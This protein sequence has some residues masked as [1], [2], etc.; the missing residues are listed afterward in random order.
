MPHLDS[1]R[2][3]ELALGNGASRDDAD[4]LRHVA[5]CG[6]C[7]EELR[8]LTRVVVAA[9]AVEE[10]DLSAT[11]PER[12]WQCL[13]GALAAAD[14]AASP[15][16]PPPRRV[17]AASARRQGVGSAP[18]ARRREARAALVLLACVLVVWWYRQGR[19]GGPSA[20]TAHVPAHHRRAGGRVR[21]GGVSVR[22]P[23]RR[24]RSG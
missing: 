5:G 2:L 3:A 14:E 9:R 4:A 22:P 10:R 13:V 8:R 19:R 17:R 12:V 15:A 20:G 24:H 16:A 6:P 18:T 1:T 11:P 21:T 23:G 7:R